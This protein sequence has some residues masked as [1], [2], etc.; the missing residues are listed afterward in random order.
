MEYIIYRFPF[1]YD[2]VN[3]NFL[4]YGEKLFHKVQRF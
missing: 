2:S 4:L 3:L 1:F